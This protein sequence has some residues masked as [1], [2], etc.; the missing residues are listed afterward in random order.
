MRNPAQS[1][2]VF[3]SP[4]FKA[5]AGVNHTYRMY[6]KMSTLSLDP[7]DACSTACNVLDRF[8]ASHPPWKQEA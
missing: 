8:R 4:L 1:A 5:P 6:L 7:G 3:L 2:A